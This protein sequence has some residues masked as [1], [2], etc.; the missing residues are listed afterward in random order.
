MGFPCRGVCRRS[1]PHS[2]AGG[3]EG[4]RRDDSAPSD[5]DRCSA[6]WGGQ[7]L[8]A[9]GERAIVNGFWSVAPEKDAFAQ[10]LSGLRRSTTESRDSVYS[11]FAVCQ[12]SGGR[13]TH[14]PGA[15]EG[16]RLV[17]QLR[18]PLLPPLHSTS[19]GSL[20][21]QKVRPGGPFKPPFEPQK[22]NNG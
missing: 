12:P 7:R 15:L 19:G 22:L 5:R 10:Y 3:N 2:D 11:A 21:A 8:G 17:T 6:A 16:L 18:D 14:A 20:E 9:V 4:K 1:C 13:P